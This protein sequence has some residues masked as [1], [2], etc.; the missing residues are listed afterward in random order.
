MYT[1]LE[2]EGGG[3]ESKQTIEHGESLLAMSFN[4]IAH[5][6]MDKPTAGIADSN[7][8]LHQQWN[9]WQKHI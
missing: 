4:S 8:N 6:T 9:E 1:E 7:C 5:R 3:M 2:L